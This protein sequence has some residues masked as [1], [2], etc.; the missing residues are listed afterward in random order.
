MEAGGAPD[1]EIAIVHTFG[2][3]RDD[4]LRALGLAEG[5]RV[6]TH[7]EVFELTAAGRVDL[8]WNRTGRPGVCVG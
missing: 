4:L 8:L 3:T 6:R 7:V 2:G 5:G 1:P